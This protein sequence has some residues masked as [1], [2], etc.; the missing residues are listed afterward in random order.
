MTLPAAFLAGVAG[1]LA[2]G[3]RH[4]AAGEYT[5]ARTAWEQAAAQAPGDPEVLW[6]MAKA[7][8]RAAA[9][10]SD[11][12]KRRAGLDRA[13]D[14]AQRS[15]AAD[16]DNSRARLALAIVYGRLALTE[17][18]RRRLE[19]SRLLRDEAEAAVR[20]D[21]RNDLAWHVLARWNFE[22]AAVHPV[23]RT[24]AR[25]VYGEL[26]PASRERALECFQK[27]IAAGPPRVMHHV[28]YGLAL[29]AIGEKK[30][31]RKQLET[32]LS[33]P[34]KDPDDENSQQRAREAL[35]ALAP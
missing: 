32:G 29:A 27:A 12:A 4:D 3:D 11:P 22:M 5:A 25:A 24:L 2:Q 14:L 8:D 34:P 18:P 21:P 15:V 6:R 33:L 13:L 20:L 26:P 31:A 30:E 10:E 35:R 28:E 17:S 16:P 19:L 9:R 7:T 23:L 1:L